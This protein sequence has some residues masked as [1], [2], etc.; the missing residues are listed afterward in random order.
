MRSVA[1][2]ELA[3]LAHPAVIAAARI[4]QHHAQ[5]AEI[6]RGQHVGQEQD[7]RDQRAPSGRQ[8]M[9]RQTRARHT[10]TRARARPRDGRRPCRDEDRRSGASRTSV[11]AC[12]CHDAAR[13]RETRG[14]SPQHGTTAAMR[15]HGSAGGSGI[16]RTSAIVAAASMPMTVP[17][18]RDG[19]ERRGR[20]VACACRRLRT[21]DTRARE[22]SRMD[23]ARAASAFGVSRLAASPAPSTSP[24]RYP[25]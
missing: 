22:I 24:R 18:M 3:S 17:A 16:T 7:V 25:D 12:A 14:R 5:P 23:E 6:V 20:T 19:A 13:R 9:R 11:T 21:V 8:T 10:S 2:G 15:S 1:A 4:A